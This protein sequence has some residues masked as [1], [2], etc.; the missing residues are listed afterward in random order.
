MDISKTTFKEYSKCDRI[1][2]LQKLYRFRLSSDVCLF[3]DERKMAAREM[4]ARMFDK[5]T[6]DD[7]LEVSDVQLET[8]QPYYRDVEKWALKIGERTF[9]L[10]FVFQEDTKKQTKFAFSEKG[11]QFYCYLD[12]YFED[13][14]QAVIVEVKAT[15]SGKFKDLRGKPTASEQGQPLFMKTGNVLALWTKF[16]PGPLPENYQNVYKKCSAVI[17]RLGNTFLIWP[18]KDISSSEALGKIIP[19]F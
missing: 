18:W 15:T 4:L 5:E 12:G 9:G 11:H 14:T 10:P 1:P 17:R 8:M 7:L 19:S 3:D 2:S 13:E 16:G 6:G